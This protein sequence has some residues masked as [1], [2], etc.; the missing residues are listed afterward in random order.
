FPLRFPVRIRSVATLERCELI[1][2]ERAVLLREAG[3]VRTAI[4]NPSRLRC[5][6]LGEEDHIGFC[7]GTVGCEGSVWQPQDAVKVTIFSQNLEHITRL[8][9]KQAIVRY[10][11]SGP[12]ARLQD[13]HDVLD[14]V[15]LLVAGRNRE[16]VT[17]W[18][19][20]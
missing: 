6:A 16:I 12:T 2:Y 11:D 4:V 10:D 14:E 15:Q 8:I 17:G 9:R 3:Y 13:R 19:L 5:V 7:T 1:R 18:S 20:I